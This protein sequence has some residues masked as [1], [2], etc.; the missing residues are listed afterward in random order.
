MKRIILILMLAAV[1]GLCT[2]SLSNER[3][4]MPSYN[5][6]TEPW[7]IVSGVLAED[8]FPCE[9]GEECPPCL[10]VVL[11]TN[12]R[13]CYL[14]AGDAQVEEQLAAA[15][16]GTQVT[17]EGKPFTR[18]KFS[19]IQV[20]RIVTEPL[21]IPSLSD[22]WHYA[23]IPA[24]GMDIPVNPE[25]YTQR[26]ATDT[27]IGGVRYRQLRGECHEADGSYLGAL[28]EGDNA[29]IYYVPVDGTHEYLLYAFKAQQGD[30][31]KNLWVGKAFNGVAAVVKSVTSDANKIIRLIGLN[32]DE[33][34]SIIWVDSVGA[35][36]GDGPACFIMYNR[37]IPYLDS[38]CKD[39]R[40]VYGG[41]SSCICAS[42]RI[43]SLCDTWN[44]LFVR[45]GPNGDEFSTE[46]HRL[47]TDTIIDGKNYVQ[48]YIEDNYGVSGRVLYRG[49]LREDNDANVYFVPA[50]SD[51]EYLLYAFNAK[52]GDKLSNL[53]VGG[54]A[55]PG[56]LPEGFN[57]RVADI[58]ETSPRVITLYLNA[59]DNMDV[60]GY[61]PIRWI[62]GVGLEDGPVGS[63]CPG[64]LG[65][66]CSCGHLLLCAYK[67]GKQVYASDE[68]EQFGCY[69][70]S[71]EQQADTVP[72]FVQGGDGPGS[73]TVEPV[74]PNQIVVIVKGDQLIIREYMDKDITYDL[75]RNF[76]NNAP[77][78][79]H[80][81]QSDTFRKSV[82]IQLTESGR[83]TIQLT[84]P[85]WD[86]SIVG[87]F[88]YMITGVPATAVPHAAQKIIRDG[89][90]LIR[91]DD[92]TY[93]LTG[94]QIE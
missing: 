3:W 72:L 35:I 22:E 37:E 85:E 74:D 59:D 26:L 12:D 19:Y 1:G 80:A 90:L 24:A 6:G 33:A 13:I 83:Y 39:G 40:K 52:V 34:V 31:L 44:V 61:M 69:Y 23:D 32:D 92:K 50:N 63:I 67:D 42:L 88:E 17:I 66:A 18:G 30:T 38:A 43:P 70:D 49:A 25:Y 29:D 16:L 81:S 4:C 8:A 15:V 51:H 47:A 58:T 28:R 87:T 20:S 75:R 93:T 45:M 86:Y 57:A 5:T 56:D 65:C 2:K 84:N 27:I 68:A 55:E 89:R 48:L 73:S 76:P 41:Q 60:N 10:T 94:V 46:I 36:S 64:V 53:W 82:T 78:R 7:I 11:R 9:E 71:N 54:L 77:A 14:T 79:E 21:R 62:E 91:H